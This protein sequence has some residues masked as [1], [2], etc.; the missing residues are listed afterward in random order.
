MTLP[1]QY[2]EFLKNYGHGGLDGFEVLGIGLDASAIF[3]DETVKYRKFGLPHNLV[4]IEN[5][6]ECLSA[7]IAKRVRSFPG[8]SE[9]GAVQESLSR[10]MTI[11]SIELKMRLTT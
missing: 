10:S 8:V 11:F 9:K 6:D 4:V 5:C 2:K 3:L 7:L 1:E